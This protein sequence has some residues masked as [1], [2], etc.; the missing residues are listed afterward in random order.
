MCDYTK[1]P[2][3]VLGCAVYGRIDVSKIRG[4]S[5][6]WTRKFRILRAQFR[7]QESNL[8]SLSKA[9]DLIKANT[10]VC[11]LSLIIIIGLVESARA[12]GFENRPF[13]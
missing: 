10:K 4:E 8:K 13:R 7:L 6:L 1:N 5:N 3:P 11:R 2:N 9:V 12:H